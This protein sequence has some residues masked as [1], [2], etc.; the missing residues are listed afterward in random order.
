[1]NFSEF[2]LPLRM[3]RQGGGI[4]EGSAGSFS[5]TGNVLGLKMSD[6]FIM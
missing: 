1:M 2:W 3:G 5:D 4:G 6:K